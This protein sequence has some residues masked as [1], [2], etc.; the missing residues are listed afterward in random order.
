MDLNRV[1]LIGHISKEPLQKAVG[2]QTLTKLHIATNHVWRDHASG[3]IKEKADFHSVVAWGKLGDSMQ[4]FLRKGE[5]VYIEGRLSNHQYEDQ[6]G[7]THYY[8]DV[9]AERMI[10]CSHKKSK[11]EG[12]DI[13]IE[14]IPEVI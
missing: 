8:T 12:D 4:K 6:A 2:K 5:P 13:K 9:V 14:D 11:A 7:V 3:E 1:E 10:L